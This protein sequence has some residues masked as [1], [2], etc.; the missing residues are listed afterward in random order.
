MGRDQE[1][2]AADQPLGQGVPPTPALPQGCQ[3][4]GKPLLLMGTALRKR[5]QLSTFQWLAVTDQRLN[6]SSQTRRVLPPSPHSVTHTPSHTVT[7]SHSVTHCH[8][9]TPSLSYILSD[10]LSHCHHHTGSLSHTFSHTQS[11]SG[12]VTHTA[13]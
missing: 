5:T 8:S 1:M 10:T 3:Y 2:Q 13:T 12:S 4:W 9:H 11:Q 6:V 7:L